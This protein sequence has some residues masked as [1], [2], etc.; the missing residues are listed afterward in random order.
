MHAKLY[1]GVSLTLTSTLRLGAAKDWPASAALESQCLWTGPLQF[2]TAKTGPVCC[3][4]QTCGSRPL[5][6]LYQVPSSKSKSEVFELKAREEYCQGD[7]RGRMFPQ[8][9][10]TRTERHCGFCVGN[11]AV[12]LGAEEE[13]DQV[14][15]G[16]AAKSVLFVENLSS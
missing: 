16:H 8:R 15:L 1:F 12:Q 4:S 2:E 3:D 7:T 11:E 6:S 5:L 13:G 14:R 10:N 9:Q